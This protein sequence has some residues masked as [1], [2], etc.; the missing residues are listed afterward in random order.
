[1]LIIGTRIFDKYP[2]IIFGFSTKI[3]NERE[4][5]F[6]FNVSFSVGDDKKNVEEN[7]NEFFSTLG[8]ASV[9]IAFQKQ[10]HGDIV[11]VVNTAG[12]CGESDAMITN[13]LNLGLAISTADCAAIFIYDPVNKV[14]AAVHSGWRGTEKK[15]LS[16][17]LFKLISDFNSKPQNLIAYIAPSI[18]MGN[19]EVGREVAKL[20]NEKYVKQKGEKFFLGVAE[21]NY[22]MLLENG[23]KPEN[24]KKSELCSFEAKELF[25]SYRRDGIRSGRT[26]G[27]IAMKKLS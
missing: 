3:G 19:Y 10:V 6:Y 9:S 23:L 12:N 24:V 13:T 21:A 20:F 8:L 14:I 27:V 26:L 15:I 16:K 4:A 5:P 1:M 25:H 2:E 22:D 18:S 11:S 17:T 7:R